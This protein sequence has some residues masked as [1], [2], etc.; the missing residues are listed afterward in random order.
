MLDAYDRNPMQVEEQIKQAYRDR[1]RKEPPENFFEPRLTSLPDSGFYNP[2]RGLPKRGI[3][4]MGFSDVSNLHV[5]LGQRG[6]VS[7]FH[8]NNAEHIMDV[9]TDLSG[10]IRYLTGES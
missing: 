10:T 4:F 9:A 1:Y 8:A 5:L 3:P 6:I 7:S 2:E